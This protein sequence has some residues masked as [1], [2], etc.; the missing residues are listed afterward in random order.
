MPRIPPALIAIL[1]FHGAAAEPC[2]ELAGAVRVESDRYLVAYRTRPDRIAVGQHFAMDV[3]VCARGGA[4]TPAGDLRVDAHMPEHRHGMNYRTTARP[5]GEAR[6]VVEGFMF[7]MP[8]RWEFIFEVRAD[9]RT[10]R[11]TRSVTLQ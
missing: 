10:D 6:Y 5:A 11:M 4:G 7:H 1:A 2:P 9:G 3:V 8:G